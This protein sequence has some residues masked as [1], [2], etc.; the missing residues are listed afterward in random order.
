[1]VD[2]V[3]S[4]S[5]VVGSEVCR[6][7]GRCWWL[8]RRV[9]ADMEPAAADSSAPATAAISAGPRT[10]FEQL[11]RVYVRGAFPGPFSIIFL[12]SRLPPTLKIWC[13]YLL[14]SVSELRGKVYRG[15]GR[16]GVSCPLGVPRGT[17]KCQKVP[18]PG[19]QTGGWDLRP[20][21]HGRPC[22]SRP[23]NA[24]SVER[25]GRDVM[26]QSPVREVINQIR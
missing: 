14:S 21:Y 13:S 11:L 16:E 19:L 8:A 3:V 22:G 6:V 1:M 20:K 23:Q 15:V 2:G 12:I 4:Q 18:A 5:G 25:H 17:S 10:W 9:G 7:W 24:E 26:A